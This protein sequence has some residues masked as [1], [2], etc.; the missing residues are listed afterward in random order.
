MPQRMMTQTES[1]RMNGAC[2]CSQCPH[3]CCGDEDDNSQ[4]TITENSPTEKVEN[5]KKEIKDLGF[6]VEEA[7]NGDIK[8]S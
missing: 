4:S 3:G 6:N 2:D 1:N 8:V 5:L 7:E